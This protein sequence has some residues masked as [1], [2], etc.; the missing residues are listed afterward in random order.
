MDLTRE[1]VIG[2]R[3]A[4]QQLDREPSARRAVT[5]A[6][7]LDLGVQDSG[8]DG[9]SWALT[10]RGVALA[11]PEALAEADELTLVWSL[12]VSPHFY[13]RAEVVEVMTAVSPFDD[14]DAAKRLVG[15]AKPMATAG[16]AVGDAIAEVARTMRAAVSEPTVKGEVSTRVTQELPGDYA[17]H[18]RPCNADHVPESLFRMA[19]LFGGLELAPATSPPVLRR[20]PGW[21]RR[22]A[23]VAAEPDRAPE[24]LQPIRG[25]LRLLGP[26]TPA[27]VAGFLDTTA[28]VVTEH[29]P[30]DAVEVS[31]G[32][33]KKW[34]LGEL[35][36][37]D[38]VVR[39]LGPYDLLVQGSDREL[40]VPEATHRKA[41]WPT[42]GRPG[43]LLADGEIVGHWRPRAKGKKLD[44]EVELWRSRAVTKARL[45]EQAERLAAHRGLGLGAISSS[46]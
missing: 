26:A 7:I 40:L 8:R 3:I 29:W 46:S 10:N 11:G 14:A 17:I 36:E 9:A 37:P 24:H 21:P 34:M 28:G 5:D 20:I 43:P 12:R 19:A 45:G 18:C 30:Q 27:E 4:A 38:R 22:P 16:V 2:H 44:L 41:L 33:K 39:L 1:Q 6:A 25:Y 15:A 13:R 42:L 23:G 32:G 35:T 31:V